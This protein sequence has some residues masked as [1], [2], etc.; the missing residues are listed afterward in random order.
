MTRTGIFVAVVIFLAIVMGL[1]ELYL[2]HAERDAMEQ[3]GDDEGLD[4][5]DRR[6]E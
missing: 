4:P 6:R 3:P 2:R 5:A 1:S